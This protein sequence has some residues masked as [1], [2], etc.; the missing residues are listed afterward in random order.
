MSLR[1]L[2][3]E[4]GGDYIISDARTIWPKPLV[5]VL[6]P[7]FN[8]EELLLSRAL[9]SVM[10]QTYDNLEILVLAHGC[11]DQTLKVVQDIQHTDIRL[12]PVHVPRH[13]TYPPTPENHW[14]A[15]PVDPLNAGLRL[16]MGR[17]IAR[18]DDDDVWVP[19]HIERSLRFAQDNDYE[20]VS[21]HHSDPQG[22][23]MPYDLGGALVGGCQTWL[24]RSYLRTFKYNPDCWRKTWNRVN[25]TDLQDRFHK[26][27]VR[28]GFQG[29]CTAHVIPRP[30]ETHVGLKAYASDPEATTTVFSF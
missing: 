5:S 6:I 8:R 13:Q 18:I 4:R 23:V 3:R 20:F 25:D 29:R 26:A 28:M 19:T 14:Y 15:G 30:G 9:P 10:E 22:M 27:G 16:A 12:K 2:R 24:Y 1:R 17:W 21:A 7:T 11:S